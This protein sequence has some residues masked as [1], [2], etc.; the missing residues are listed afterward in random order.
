MTDYYHIYEMKM[1]FFFWIGS[2]IM[3]QK[4]LIKN[5][6]KYIKVNLE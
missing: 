6:H 3:S 1:L 5:L 2:D 4:D